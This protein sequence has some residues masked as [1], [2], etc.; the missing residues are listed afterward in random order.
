MVSESAK[1]A[2]AKYQRDKMES[3]SIRVKRSEGLY[4]RIK[5]AAAAEGI[6]TAKYIK[7]AIEARL[8]GLQPDTTPVNGIIVAMNDT[9]VH[10]VDQAVKAGYGTSRD[11]YII[12]ATIEQLKRD[13]DNEIAKRRAARSMPPDLPPDE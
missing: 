6:A 7:Q 2:T 4:N 1:M 8:D 11:Q 5:T 3:I 10:S 12:H 13:R 9:T